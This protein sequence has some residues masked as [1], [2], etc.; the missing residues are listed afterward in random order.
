VDQLVE[1]KRVDLATIELLEPLP[2]MIVT[3]FYVKPRSL[4]PVFGCD[5]SEPIPGCEG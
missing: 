4:F 1:L 2:H 5:R 3:R